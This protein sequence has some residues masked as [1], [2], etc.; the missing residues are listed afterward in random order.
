VAV[1]KIV[2]DRQAVAT[3]FSFG[4]TSA[5]GEGLVTINNGTAASSNLVLDVKGTADFDGNV[6]IGGDLNLTGDLNITGNVNA[7]SVTN[8]E[9]TDL[10]ITL[11]DGGSTPTDDTAG[12]II[13]GTGNTTVGA[14]YWNNTSATKFSIGTGASQQDIVG[15]SAT[16]TLT[17]KT[18]TTPTIGDFSNATHN[19]T[20]A[21]NGGQLTDAALSSAVGV[22][23]GGTGRTTNTAYAIMAG[24]TTSTGAQQQVSGLGTSGQV[25]TSNGAG[26]LPSWQAIP[27]G[28]SSFAVVTVSGTQ[29]SSNKTFTLGSTISSADQ[30]FLNGQLLTP[31]STN[32]YEISGTTLTFTASFTAPASTDVIRA[33][34]NV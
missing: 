29:D 31:G 34:G 23:K 22:A 26:A 30:I 5:S 2:L 13:E 24:G 8:L 16:Q 20:N 17:N 1:S 15:E 9:V 12:I 27:G 33:Y 3:D 6:G 25:L 28:S 21:A 4:T 14:I 10:T 7:Q 32:D 11:N 19:H 18:L